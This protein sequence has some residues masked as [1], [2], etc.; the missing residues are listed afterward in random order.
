MLFGFIFGPMMEEF[1]RHALLLSKGSPLVL[2]TRSIS[3][4]L[5][6][7]AALI[8]LTILLPALRKKRAEVFIEDE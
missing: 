2:I 4:T 8:M 5:L 6:I 7:M 3:A 1:L